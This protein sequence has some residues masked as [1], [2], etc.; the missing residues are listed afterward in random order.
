MQT[1]VRNS[2]I[3]ACLIGLA[4][5]A[6]P[7]PEPV[8]VQPVYDKFGDAECPDNYVFDNLVC[9]PVPQR[10]PD[11][12]GQNGEDGDRDPGRNQGPARG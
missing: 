2:A 11:R 5:C 3:Y 4:A 6:A 1:I 10:E 9:V 8:T 7:P 12:S